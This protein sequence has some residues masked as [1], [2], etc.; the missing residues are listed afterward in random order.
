MSDIY[1]DLRQNA[2][3]LY[4]RGIISQNRCV[5]LLDL[6]PGGMIRSK[7]HAAI[8]W[9]VKQLVEVSNEIQKEAR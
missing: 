6:R 1:A 8:A 2:L 5:D 4:S 3:K 7:V 9:G